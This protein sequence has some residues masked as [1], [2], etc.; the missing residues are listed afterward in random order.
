L[1]HGDLPAAPIQTGPFPASP[2]KHH[3]DMEPA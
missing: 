2:P 3:L 1:S